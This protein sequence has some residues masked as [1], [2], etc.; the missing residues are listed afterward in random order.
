MRN[1]NGGLNQFTIQCRLIRT[2][3]GIKMKYR[4][5]FRSIQQWS[6][7]NIPIKSTQSDQ[8]AK[9]FDSALTQ[10]DFRTEIFYFSTNLNITDADFSMS[11]GM[12]IKLVWVKHCPNCSK[13]IRILFSDRYFR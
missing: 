13:K 4:R 2:P 12:T 6:K 11:D 5:D 9:L 10:V 3:F 1:D 7:Q 8:A